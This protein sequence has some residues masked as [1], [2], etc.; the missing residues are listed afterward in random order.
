MGSGGVTVMPA[1]GLGVGSGRSDECGRTGKARTS[2]GP[3][4]ERCRR[5]DG[6]W[7]VVNLR[8]PPTGLQGKNRRISR[9]RPPAGGPPGRA[10]APVSES[11]GSP[12]V[13]ESAGRLA[14]GL[15]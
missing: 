11:V 3:E 14:L 4:R 8:P 10:L 9:L 1:G 2:L 7:M 15:I 5:L 6:S 12:S 13:W